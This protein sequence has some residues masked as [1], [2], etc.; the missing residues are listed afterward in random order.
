M[1]RQAVKP[2]HVVLINDDPATMETIRESIETACPQ[3][4]LHC[5]EFLFDVVTRHTAPIDLVFIDMTSVAG[6]VIGWQEFDRYL[7]PFVQFAR[8]H[9]SAVFLIC[10]ALIHAAQDIAEE[11]RE[12]L[13]GE[14]TVVGSLDDCVGSAYVD[15]VIKYS[16]M[17]SKAKTSNRRRQ[18]SAAHATD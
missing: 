3:V 1:T 18:R 16:P 4:S 12:R 10:S 15:A 13:S 7:D 6:G 5:Y 11:V 9:S 14:N 8:E 17:S 2:F